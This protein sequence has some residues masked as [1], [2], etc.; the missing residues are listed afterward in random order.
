M[1]SNGRRVESRILHVVC[2][3][4]LTDANVCLGKRYNI[5]H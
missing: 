4:L 2:F 3:L 1:R 5:V